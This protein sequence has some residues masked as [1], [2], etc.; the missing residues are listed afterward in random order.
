MAHSSQ[1]Q[2]KNGE[3]QMSFSIRAHWIDFVFLPSLM[4]W[5]YALWLKNENEKHKNLSLCKGL[6]ALESREEKKVSLLNIELNG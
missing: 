4:H 1:T 2:Q 3:I 5:H 6:M